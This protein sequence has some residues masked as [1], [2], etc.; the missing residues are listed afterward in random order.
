MSPSINHHHRS[1]L[2]MHHLRQ[3]NTASHE[4]QFRGDIVPKG[5]SP[6]PNISRRDCAIVGHDV[7]TSKTP[8]PEHRQYTFNCSEVARSALV[9]AETGKY[10]ALSWY[11]GHFQIGD[12]P[13][14]SPTESRSTTSLSTFTSSPFHI[15]PFHSRI[16]PRRDANSL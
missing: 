12:Q 11:C 7:P 3:N 1:L 14:S 8:S 10:S 5:H 6:L 9:L 2:R 13:Y 15:L 16:R 4:W